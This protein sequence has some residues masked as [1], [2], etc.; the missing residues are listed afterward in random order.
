MKEVNQI[1]SW[2]SLLLIVLIVFWSFADQKPAADHMDSMDP[3]DFSLENVVEHLKVIAK[4]VHHVGTEAH[5]EVQAY[6]IEEL[7]ALGL[8][9]Q[10]HRQ[11]VFRLSS[12]FGSGTVVE[13]IIA[14]IEGT[15]EGKSLML[16]SHYDSAMPH[17]FGA[18]DDG[19]GIATILEGLRVFLGKNE[20]PKNDI[21]ILFSD[22]EELGLFG[23]RAFV[24]KHPWADDV[25]LIL[26][27]EARGSGGPSYMLME[28]N[29]KNSKMLTE[30]IKANP[31]YPTTNSLSY[32]VYKMLPNDTDLTPLR[33]IGNINGFNFAFIDDHFDYHTAQDTWQRIDRETL[34]HQ[35]DYLMKTLNY[36]AH[37]DIDDLNSEHDRIFVNFPFVKLIHYP[38][39]WNI[40]LF[41]LAT[42][43][44]IVLFVLGVRAGHISLKASANGFIPFLLS[45]IGCCLINFG[46]WRLLLL[47]HPQYKDFVHGFTYNGYYYIGGFAAINVW[48]SLYAYKRWFRKRNDSDLLA[49]PI[50]F[51]LIINAALLKYL[52]GASFLIIP[53]FMAL[54]MLGVLIF[55]NL[56]EH[57]KLIFFIVLSIP[58]IYMLAPTI[59]LFPV[60]LGLG[61]LAVG[62][63]FLVMIL[64][65]L[66]PVISIL[67]IRKPL[68][69][70]S[71][72]IA[73]V[74]LV[75]ATISSGFN[76]N[77]KKP[78]NITF[79]YNADKNVS[80]WASYNHRLDPF[81]KQFLGDNP[82]RGTL[83]EDANF[84]NPRV[85]YYTKTDNRDLKIS[86]VTLNRDTLIEKE[87][88][89]DFTITPK[90]K[91]NRIHLKAR[92]DLQLNRMTINGTPV[93]AADY[94]DDGLV[95]Q[96][97]D[98]IIRYNMSN[99]DEELR[100]T[101][102]MNMEVAPNFY[103]EE[104]SYDL[105]SNELFDIAPRSED[106]MPFAFSVGDA[107][108]TRQTVD[109][110]AG[111]WSHR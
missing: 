48:L 105:L 43:L 64:G 38:F 73:L 94:E 7:K 102:A 50:V 2:V 13:N 107:I 26:N 92:E 42:V 86:E 70:G 41:I 9:P 100:I 72:A 103:L 98:Y 11:R 35:A 23:A 53:V 75:I 67:S 108:V 24:E 89:I 21:I 14:R 110:E 47:I 84:I 58:S 19:S 83:P 6:L 76:E 51:W 28:T 106:M 81:L 88:F 54:I 74:L 55:T 87:R 3:A 52:P 33:E 12:R 82:Q 5:R 78:N 97:D 57:I 93:A 18:S 16:L 31:S 17:S 25:G 111:E 63:L 60:G 40:P 56:S 39:S 27:F 99:V 46:L 95:R 65:L 10:I 104:V 69:L 62:S 61:M 30:F 79:Y 101:V 22:A 66:V 49:A 109:F 15:R 4:D 68:T 80:Y 77:R 96:K 59:K 8:S 91:V 37:S 71:G 90:R 36:F 34:A 45:L 85:R 44:F 32:S 20:K 29:G 1:F